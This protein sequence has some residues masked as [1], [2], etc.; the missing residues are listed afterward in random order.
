M[1]S[2]YV[3]VEHHGDD[4]IFLR[5]CTRNDVRLQGEGSSTALFF[6]A[7]NENCVMAGKIEK[8]DLKSFHRLTSEYLICNLLHVIHSAVYSFR[9]Q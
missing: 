9:I 8:A 1:Y 2:H 5:L 3:L 4:Q 7:N 6:P